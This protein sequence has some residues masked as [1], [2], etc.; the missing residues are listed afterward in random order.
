MFVDVDKARDATNV[1]WITES[2]MLDL[3]VLAGPGPRE[4]LQQYAVLTGTT[5]MPQM[6]AIG[7]HQCRWAGCRRWASD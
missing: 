1:Q 5:S 7:Y 3:F 4:V 2:G 6:F